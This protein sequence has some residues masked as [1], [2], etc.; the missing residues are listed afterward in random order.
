MALVPMPVSSAVDCRLS[1]Q[2]SGIVDTPVSLEFL[3]RVG[4]WYYI[5][6]VW[7]LPC[8]ETVDHLFLVLG[9]VVIYSGNWIVLESRQFALL[10]GFYLELL[11]V[12]VSAP[13]V[14]LLVCGCSGANLDRLIAFAS[15]Q[16]QVSVIP[17]CP[18]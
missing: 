2:F 3:I 4:L 11:V 16:W 7:V 1:S 6:A 14:H 13:F 8:N 18:N 9:L 12:E 5:L 10:V 17:E 15:S